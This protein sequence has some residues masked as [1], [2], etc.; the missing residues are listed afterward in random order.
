MIWEGY[1]NTIN[2][3]YHKQGHAERR[4]MTRQVEDNKHLFY[5]I[6][7]WALS[8]VIALGS[9]QYLSHVKANEDALEALTKRIDAITSD[10]L[11]KEIYYRDVTEIKNKLDMLITMHIEKSVRINK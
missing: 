5:K 8:A 11:D 3:L 1:F 4:S 10:K 2:M 6:A 7:T 9:Y